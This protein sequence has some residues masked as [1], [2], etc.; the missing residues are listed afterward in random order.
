MFNAD[1]PGA[2]RPSSFWEGEIVRSDGPPCRLSYDESGGQRPPPGLAQRASPDLQQRP[3]GFVNLNCA[4]GRGSR[5]PPW[6][7]ALN[8]GNSPVPSRLP[9]WTGGRQPTR[10]DTP[11]PGPSA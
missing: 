5:H 6:D 3:A 10:T 1:A 11:T 2:A 9:L 4:I 8:W 7:S